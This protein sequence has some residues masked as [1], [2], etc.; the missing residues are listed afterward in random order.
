MMC[1]NC[2]GLSLASFDILLTWLSQPNHQHIQ[3][4]CLQETH[5]KHNHEW[6]TEDWLCVHDHDPH[7]TYAGVLILI[8]KRIATSSQIRTKSAHSGRI[9]QVRFL[10]GDTHVD[11]INCYQVPW[12]TRGRKQ[13]LLAKRDSVWRALETTLSACPQRNLVCVMGDFNCQL[14][15]SRAQVGTSTC[16]CSTEQQVAADG[17][18]FLRF[19]EHFS[20][21]ALNTFYL[22]GQV[23]HTY[24]QGQSGTQIDY[25][26][27]RQAGADVLSKRAQV[28]HNFSVDRLRL[29]CG[30][31]PVLASVSTSGDPGSTAS[32]QGLASTCSCS[33]MTVEETPLHPVVSR[34]LYVELC[35][36]LRVHR[37]SMTIHLLPFERHHGGV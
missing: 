17:A 12:N 15:P 1:W 16:I 6:Q 21:V 25:I 33:G 11:I 7:H 27:T 13:T 32:P 29:G 35:R 37:I 22:K 34:T 4:V 26:L 5:W 30:H 23:C 9:L 2:G 3:V 14:A 10:V 8:S 24:Q 36:Q 28:L 18:T 31:S 19:L 20:L